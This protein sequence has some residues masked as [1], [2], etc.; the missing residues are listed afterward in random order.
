ME[1]IGDIGVALSEVTISHVTRA[2]VEFWEFLY[3][4]KERDVKRYRNRKKKHVE[5]SLFP[6]SASFHKLK[7]FSVVRL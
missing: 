6:F 7:A 2:R 3:D 4:V 5:I 1:C